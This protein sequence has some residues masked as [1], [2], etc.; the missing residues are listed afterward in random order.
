M[1]NGIFNGMPAWQQDRQQC[2][3][4]CGCRQAAEKGWNQRHRKQH[5]HDEEYEHG[6]DDDD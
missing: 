2:R 5:E 1:G 6:S 3:Q 4:A